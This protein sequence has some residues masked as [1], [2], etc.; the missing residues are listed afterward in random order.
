MR[1]FYK[2]DNCFYLFGLA[3]YCQQGLEEGSVKEE[4][5]KDVRKA[6]NVGVYAFIGFLALHFPTDIFDVAADRAA[7]YAAGVAGL[8]AS[9]KF[10]ASRLAKWAAAHGSES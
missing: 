2:G 1:L 3:I 5:V 9:A 8:A 7:L 6:I 10:I 4:L